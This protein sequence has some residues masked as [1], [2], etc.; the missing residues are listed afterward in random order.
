MRDMYLSDPVSFD[1]VLQKLAELENQI[2]QA[3]ERNAVGKA[4]Q[5]AT[6]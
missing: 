2:N 3:A 5:N 6:G 1:E 4:S